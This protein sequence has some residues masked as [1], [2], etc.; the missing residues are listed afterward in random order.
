MVCQEG[1]RFG[2]LYLYHDEKNS[3][4]NSPPVGW[5]L[6]QH[7]MLLL[8]TLHEDLFSDTSPLILEEV[9]DILINGSL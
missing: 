1:E 2:F 3:G 8:L 7:L 9:E 4:I 6:S 5:V